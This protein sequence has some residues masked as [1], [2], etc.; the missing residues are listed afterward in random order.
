VGVGGARPLVDVPM[1]VLRCIFVV[2]AEGGG[3]RCCKEV[4]ERKL[5]RQRKHSPVP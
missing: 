4:A 1:V 5:A 2:S 3:G